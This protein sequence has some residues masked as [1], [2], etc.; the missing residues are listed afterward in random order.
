[1]SAGRAFYHRGRRV[2]AR[3]IRLGR[4]AIREIRTPSPVEALMAALPVVDTAVEGVAGRVVVVT[5]ATRGVGLAVVRR[6]GALG[7]RIVVNGR[8]G[9]AVERTV[10]TL[11]KA[12]IEA[13]GVTA[14][15]SDADGAQA[16]VEGAVAA[17]GAVDIL[18]NNAAVAGPHD[19]VWDVAPGAVA[20]TVRANLTGPI[21]CTMAAVRW[22][23][24]A[25]RGGRVVNVSSIATQGNYPRMMPYATTKAALEAFTRS[26]AADLP[27]G[28]VVV[29][30][31][32]LPSVQTERKFAADWAAT[33]LLP[34]VE[35]V[36]PAF[37]YCATGPAG[38]LHG[39]TI[40]AERFM[41]DPDAEAQVAGPAATRRQITYP[42]LEIGGR[43]AVRDPGALTLLDRAENQHGVSPAVLAAIAESLT[44]HPP[45][46]YPDD[47]FDALRTAL[48]EEHGL[49]PACFALGPGSWELISRIVQIFAKPGEEVVSNG[50][51]W[52]GFNL[53]CQRQGVAQKLVAMDRGATGNR[54]SHNLREMLAAITPRTRLV[55][56]I[57]PS[58]PEGVTLHHGEL[59]EFLAALPVHLPV[60][61]DEAYAEFAD[62]PDMADVPRLTREND[63]TLIGLRTFSK[64]HGLAGMRVG[65][66]YAREPV[67]DLIRRSEQ[68]FT[69]THVS[70]VA[71]VAALKDRGHRDRVF[72]AATEARRR[73]SRGLDEIG[74]AHIGSH[75]PFI[76]AD[77][78]E[79]FDKAVAELAG[80]GIIIAPYR[81]NGDASVML[82][83]GSEA[84]VDRILDVLR[85]HR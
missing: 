61:I 67:A 18:I 50:P 35:S 42:A 78:P 74:I 84:Q 28:D 80:E 32:I 77:A 44:S 59:S 10:A 31:V 69:L 81:F 54:P 73:M 6:F 30:A 14:D 68:I 71:A 25:G 33:E 63:R 45:A 47:R 4:S 53:T 51:G 79:G 39:R 62:D 76:F 56:L 12:G 58:N 27:Q 19:P 16:L 52:F 3:A 46:F 40:S 29:S 37:E 43:R 49:A 41:T 64:F 7:G 5:G 22:M 38:L 26:V 21:L 75:A 70:E 9:G 13:A 11:R 8:R 2:V 17:F 65:Y 72:A 85:R 48:A 66:A 83:V 55:Y 24:G 36:L 57:S 20:E 1:M 34:P 82:P 60:L 23:R 15:V